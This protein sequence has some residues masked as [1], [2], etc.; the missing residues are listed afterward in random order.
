MAKINLRS[1]VTNTIIVFFLSVIVLVNAD[2]L[3]DISDKDTLTEN[4]DLVTLSDLKQV[5]DKCIDSPDILSTVLIQ[6][7]IKSLENYYNDNFGF[8]AFFIYLNNLYKVKVLSVSPK[9]A[10]VIGKNNWLYF[11]GDCNIDYY[12]NTKQFTPEELNYW[13]FALEAKRRWLAK[14]GIYHLVVFAPNKES[15]YPEFLPASVRRKRLTETSL[16]DQLLKHLSANSKLNVLD[17]RTPLRAL[18]NRAPFPLYHR[19]DTHWNQF[20]AYASYYEIMRCL[21]KDFPLLE[22]S[23][24]SDFDVTQKEDKGGDLAGMLALSNYFKE[25]TPEFV[26]RSPARA[27]KVDIG[28][29]V[30]EAWKAEVFESPNPGLPRAIMIH[31]SFGGMLRPFLSEHFKKIVYLRVAGIKYSMY[32]E[33]EVIDR[34][35]P[36]IVIEEIVER[37]LFRFKPYLPNEIAEEFFNRL[38]SSGG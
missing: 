9:E 6:N 34:E 21:N 12:A 24:L 11:A 37:K 14:R 36:D 23:L 29:N 16:L 22:P 27:Q 33:T 3:F 38:P 25:V 30:N 17:L 19:T 7:F 31:D 32:F 28:Y 1:C 5:V 8:R 26:S 35:R 20:G 15:V 18:K 2:Y 4:R 13:Q 10:V